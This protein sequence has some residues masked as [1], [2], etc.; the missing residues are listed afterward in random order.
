MKEGGRPELLAFFVCFPLVWKTGSGIL[1]ASWPPVVE[2]GSHCG[3]VTAAPSTLFLLLH[4]LHLFF[5]IYPTTEQHTSP[6]EHN[7][8]SY[9]IHIH[10]SHSHIHTHIKHTHTHQTHTHTRSGWCLRLLPYDHSLM[11]LL[12][13]QLLLLLMRER[14]P[15][16]SSA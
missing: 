12:L 9:N 5:K 8:Y 16:F 10:L 14:Q 7:I 4:F 6:E 13:L 11:P 2:N 15:C 1:I 3:R